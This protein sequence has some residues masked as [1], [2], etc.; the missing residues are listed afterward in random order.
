MKTVLAVDLGGTKT[1]LA[2]VDEHGVLHDR[3]KLPAARSVEATLAQIADGAGDVEAVGVIV[4]GIYTPATGR[5]W[6]PN[7][8]GLDEVPLLAA[9]GAIL[10]VAVAID[11]DRVG[12]VIG[13][14]WLGAGQ[15]L[16]DV[17][18][19]SI[20]TGIGVGILSN[21]VVVRGAHGIAGAAGWFALD[22]EF[23]EAY[24][25]VGCWEA[26]AAG[27]AIARLAGAP[28]AESV[29]A[30]ARAGSVAASAV[31]RRAAAYTAR[32]I[33]TLISALNPEL[34]VLGGGLMQG[35]GDLFLES[36]R[37]DV[38]KW[39]QPIAASHC[40][41]TLTQLGEDA[42]LLGAARLA[43]DRL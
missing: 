19:V 39:A 9:L 22:P 32:G 20:G 41:L 34:V 35:A 2:R 14:S 42:G 31:L 25:E 43:F 23:K 21:G 30:A 17:V 29:V 6:C 8:W 27:P 7:L 24:A 1:A 3:R 37:A 16:R 33:A 18:F 15:G 40:R 38:G 4:P 36:V 12:Y 13:E 10:P 28:D 26:N 11:S 5:A